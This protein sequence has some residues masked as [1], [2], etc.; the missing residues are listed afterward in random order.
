MNDDAQS[1]YS[2]T[3]NKTNQTHFTAVTYA[4]DMLGISVSE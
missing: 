3:T 1:I 4:T 2:S